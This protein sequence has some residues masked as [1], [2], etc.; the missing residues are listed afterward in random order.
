MPLL[1]GDDFFE[2]IEADRS[3]FGPLH[4]AGL[5]VAGLGRRS[6]SRNRCN[7]ASHGPRFPH[8]VVAHFQDFHLAA[9][10]LF[11][12]EFLGHDDFLQPQKL[13]AA[14]GVGVFEGNRHVLVADQRGVQRAGPLGDDQLVDFRRLDRDGEDRVLTDRSRAAALSTVK[15]ASAPVA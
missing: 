8:A 5:A 15:Y 7:A 4:A 13:A 10:P 1:G 12:G 6:G 11:D 2:R 9:G 3:G 14:D